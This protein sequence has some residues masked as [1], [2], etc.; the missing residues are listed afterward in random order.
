MI[1]PNPAVGT[2][3]E[4]RQPRVF[5]RYHE[6]T[7]GSQ[8]AGTLR[9]EKH[10]GTLAT[11]EYGDRRWTFKRTGFWSPRVSVREEGSTAD[12]AILTPKWK[13]GGELI[14]QTGRRFTLKSLS[15]WGGDWAF[16]TDDGA[17]VISV[18]GPHGLI[19]NK[20][21]ASVGLS[22][23]RLPETPVLLLLIWYL[24]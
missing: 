21:E 3:L 24:R 10:F 18:H 23:S 4:W 12:I 7:A 20:G 5:E 19:H 14:F 9:F 22:A 16:E 13:G 15:F 1:A 17:E 11:A 2:R 6:L 8:L